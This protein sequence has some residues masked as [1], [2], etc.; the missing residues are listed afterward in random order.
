MV[1]E[2]W[3]TSDCDGTVGSRSVDQ[4]SSPRGSTAPPCG[5]LDYPTGGKKKPQNNSIFCLIFF[6]F[7][8]E[9]AHIVNVSLD[10]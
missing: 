7:F 3:Q 1:M 9:E 4:W 8:S 5:D 10:I 6:I 2:M